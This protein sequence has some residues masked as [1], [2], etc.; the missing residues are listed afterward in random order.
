MRSGS[1]F[2]EW[3]D[4]G[5]NPPVHGTL[6]GWTAATNTLL[7]R[8]RAART[9]IATTQSWQDFNELMDVLGKWMVHT[10]LFALIEHQLAKTE[11]Q[12]AALAKRDADQKFDRFYRGSARHAA[13]RVMQG[14][15]RRKKEPLTK[16]QNEK[17]S[18]LLEL[19]R[20][21]AKSAKRKDKNQTQTSQVQIV[22]LERQHFRKAERLANERKQMPFRLSKNEMSCIPQNLRGICRTYGKDLGLGFPCLPVSGGINI[23]Q[24]LPRAVRRHEAQAYLQPCSA[25][26]AHIQ[27]TLERRTTMERHGGEVSFAHAKLKDVSI[28][29]PRQIKGL[30]ADGLS[31]MAPLTKRLY[32]AARDFIQS[33]DGKTEDLCD[34]DVRWA[35]TKVA[36]KK[37][38]SMEHNKAFPVIKTMKKAIPELVS[39]GL[40]IAGKPR[41]ICGKRS[42]GWLWPLTHKD[43]RE[44]DLMVFPSV[45]AQ[46]GSMMS[47]CAE[48]LNIR[49]FVSPNGVTR[50][51][52]MVTM[53]S[54]IER[55]HFSVDDLVALSHEVGHSLHGLSAPAGR[56]VE[57][58]MEHFGWDFLEFPSQLLELYPTDPRVLARW[59]DTDKNPEWASPS[60]WHSAM[61]S[62]IVDLTAHCKQWLMAWSDISM[63][64]VTH[65]EPNIDEHYRKSIKRFGLHEGYEPELAR[66]S[67]CWDYYASMDFSYPLGRALATHF[68]PMRSNGSVNAKDLRRVMQSLVSD[69]LQDGH[70]PKNFRKK[71]EEWTGQN[72]ET[73]MRKAVKGYAQTYRGHFL[74]AI[75]IMKELA[76]E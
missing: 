3:I 63:H 59:A 51:L 21:E 57:D 9:N 43:G 13:S 24:Y 31:Q 54:E 58:G 11:M 16:L 45:Q 37:C 26:S 48:N 10:G 34:L 15:L 18:E 62:N 40:W 44:A 67:F 76:A 53:Y 28:R 56:D 30:L 6:A 14:W 73:M 5:N 20:Q 55:K 38:P 1:V 68:A 27:S 12:A 22:R 60:S 32:K 23:A 70:N 33:E 72:F 61:Y 65:K 7:S 71:M 19:F 17:V 41:Q 42:S 47:T 2:L 35:L 69:V 29:S 52:V 64:S 66:N 50:A 4:G 46:N 25:N 49:G 39:C 36:N 75:N 8:A 74:D